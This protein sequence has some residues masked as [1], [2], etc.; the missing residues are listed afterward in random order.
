MPFNIL[1]LLCCVTLIPL[2][3]SKP[4]PPETPKAPRLRLMLAVPNSLLA[5]VGVVVAALSGASFRMVGP[6]YG[7]EVGLKLTRSHTFWR[8][9]FSVTRWHRFQSDGWPTNMIGA[10]F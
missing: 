10:K 3:L 1:A 2:A 9:S 7:T 8:P 5:A 4:R 6:I